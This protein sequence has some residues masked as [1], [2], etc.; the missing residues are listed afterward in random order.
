MDDLSSSSCHSQNIQ[1]CHKVVTVSYKLATTQLQGCYKAA[2][3]LLQGY[4][5][6]TTLLFGC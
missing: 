2:T 1:G 4:D 3:K 5:K 6:V